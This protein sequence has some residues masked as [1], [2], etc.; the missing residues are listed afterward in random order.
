MPCEARSVSAP[1]IGCMFPS[2]MIHAC[3]MYEL[4]SRT[5]SL[6]SPKAGRRERIRRSMGTALETRN[7]S[8]AKRVSPLQLGL[9][10][11]E[12]SIHRYMVAQSDGRG[13]GHCLASLHEYPVCFVREPRKRRLATP[14]S[15]QG[16]AHAFGVLVPVPRRIFWRPGASH[17]LLTG[18]DLLLLVGS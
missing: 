13:A 16:R 17:M 1:C 3:C 12:C 15:S 2:Y 9:I 8:S 5:C 11:S 18:S 14:Q 10:D 4:P 7:S 6:C